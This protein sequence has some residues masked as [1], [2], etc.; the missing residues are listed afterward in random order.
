M[1]SNSNNDQDFFKNQ[2]IELCRYLATNNNTFDQISESM[3]EWNMMHCNASLSVNEI[4]KLIDIS[5]ARLYKY[6]EEHG[7]TKYDISDHLN[8]INNNIYGTDITDDKLVE[9]ESMKQFYDL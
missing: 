5:Y 2:R 1:T 8:N 7:R 3:N 9:I 6:N 4:K